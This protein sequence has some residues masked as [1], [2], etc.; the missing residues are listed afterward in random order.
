MIR[1]LWHQQWH[2]LTASWSESVA[3]S[4]QQHAVFVSN[5]QGNVSAKIGRLGDTPGH[6]QLKLRWL[7]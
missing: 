1:L 3:Y 2:T 4:S 6:A 5:V 7:G